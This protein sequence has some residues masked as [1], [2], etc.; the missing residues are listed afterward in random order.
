MRA[1]RGLPQAYVVA[2]ALLA[3]FEEGVLIERQ[4]AS[5]KIGFAA[6]RLGGDQRRRRHPENY[7]VDIGK[8][9]PV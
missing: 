2:P 8:L 4:A 7:P 9:T 6:R 5:L 1:S 3:K